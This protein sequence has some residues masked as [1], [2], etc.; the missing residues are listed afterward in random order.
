MVAPQLEREAMDQSPHTSGID[1]V[2]ADGGAWVVAAGVSTVLALGTVMFAVERTAR[3]QRRPSA[4]RRTALAAYL[5]EH[6]AGAHAATAVVDQLRRTRAGTTEGVL[7]AR[8][9]DEFLQE[10]EVLRWL[11]ADIGMSPMSR[12]RSAGQAIGTA[13]RIVAVRRHGELSLFRTLE[14]LTIGVQGKRCLWRA[15]QVLPGM[16]APDGQS[17]VGLEAQALAQWEAI[18]ECRR[19]LAIDTFARTYLPDF[20][21]S[22]GGGR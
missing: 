3:R 20:I 19:S 1:D 12:K 6:L 8:L 16:P 22:S 10:Q 14:G 17:F 21:E 18:D 4:R 5:R 13:L 15:L 9:R 11:L 2:E 7:A